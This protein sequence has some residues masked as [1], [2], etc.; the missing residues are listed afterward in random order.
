MF[1]AAVLNDSFAVK[2][3]TPYA[4]DYEEYDDNGDGN[5]NATEDQD[6]DNDTAKYID[7]SSRSGQVSR[8]ANYI[9]NLGFLGISLALLL[10]GFNQAVPDNTRVGFIIAFGILVGFSNDFNGI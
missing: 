9:Y 7:A 5:I 2:S 4:L 8:I 10:G 3:Q 1:V 6:R